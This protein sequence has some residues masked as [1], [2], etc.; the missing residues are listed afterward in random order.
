MLSKRPIWIKRNKSNSEFYLRD[1]FTR[2]VSNGVIR[3]Q[4]IPE[5]SARVT[6]VDQHHVF[7]NAAATSG[8][9]P[10][11]LNLHISLFDGN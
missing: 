11:N 6:Q 1:S 4:T 2:Q 3:L 7:S 9:V 5:G 8:L 10:F